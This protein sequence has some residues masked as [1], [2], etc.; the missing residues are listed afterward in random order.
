MHRRTL[1]ALPALGLLLSACGGGDPQPEEIALTHLVTNELGL[2]EPGTYVIRSLNELG[3]FWAANPNDRYPTRI[4]PDVDFSRHAIVGIFAG[5]KP[6]CSTL[7]ITGAS[8]LDSV[9]TVR[10][11]I[12]TVITTPSSCIGN[13]TFNLNLGDLVLVPRDITEVRTVR[14]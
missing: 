9:L 12:D 7:R 5:P 6:R 4:L 3:A 14:E 11:R 2:V 13:D 1:L 8:R 10:W